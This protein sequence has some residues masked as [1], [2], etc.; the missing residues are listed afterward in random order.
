M[1]IDYRIPP[2]G[3]IIEN[4]LLK[5]N[6]PIPG[7][8]IEV[9]SKGQNKWKE[10]KWSN[11]VKI[12]HIMKFQIRT[13]G[14][15]EAGEQKFACNDYTLTPLSQDLTVLSVPISGWKH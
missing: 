13:R 3:A 8:K 15:V 7:L 4:G 14:R 10:V 12:G 5:V 11:P 1:N 9:S 2:P 6:S